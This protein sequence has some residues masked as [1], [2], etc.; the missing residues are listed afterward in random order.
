MGSPTDVDL[1][2]NWQVRTIVAM[3]VLML[4]NLSIGTLVWEGPADTKGASWLLI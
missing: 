1:D 3:V 4:V 2:P